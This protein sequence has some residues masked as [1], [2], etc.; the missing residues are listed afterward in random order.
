MASPDDAAGPTV[1]GLDDLF[2]PGT[3][4]EV[5]SSFNGRWVGG[6]QVATRSSGGYRL[7]RL[8]DQTVLP[9]LFADDEVRPV[10]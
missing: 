3:S 5:F 4:V 9:V 2:E 10:W 8:S 7:R 1:R 6:F